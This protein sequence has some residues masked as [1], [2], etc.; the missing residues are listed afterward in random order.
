MK[1]KTITLTLGTLSVLLISI[2][3]ADAHVRQG[4]WLLQGTA[5]FSSSSGDLY[6]NETLTTF[7]L[8]PTVHY[9]IINKLALGGKLDV[10]S[11]SQGNNSNTSLFV[12]P[13]VRYFLAKDTDAYLNPYLG[14]AILLRSMSSETT[15]GN[16]TYKSDASGSSILVLERASCLDAGTFFQSGES[17]RKQR[18]DHHAGRRSGRFS[19]Y[20][21]SSF[22]RDQMRLCTDIA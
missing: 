22:A 7:S 14:A 10:V 18:H 17:G 16:T 6:G 13:S 8:S 21:R 12:G 20:S 11:R 3:T 9:F 5:A 1:W 19:L 2:G 4:T 15:I